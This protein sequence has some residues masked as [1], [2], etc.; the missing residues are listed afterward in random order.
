MLGR[1]LTKFAEAV[2]REDI[3][4][5]PVSILAYPSPVAAQISA[6]ANVVG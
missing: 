1:L 5:K 6:F 2:P 3:D 4:E